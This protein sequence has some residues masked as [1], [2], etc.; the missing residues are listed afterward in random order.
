VKL[1]FDENLPAELAG[2]L[3]DIYPASTS[4]AEAL[5]RPASDMEV[6]NFARQQ[7]FTIATKDND[8][9]QLA[10]LRGYPPKVIWLRCGNVP[11]ERIEK[12]LREARARVEQFASDSQN[13]LLVLP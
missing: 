9:E 3:A 6:W 4:V 5:Q 13:A 8:F 7:G 1:L 10:Y 12:L 2:R 11:T